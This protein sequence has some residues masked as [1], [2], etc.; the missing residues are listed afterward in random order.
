[1]TRRISE[2][3][4]TKPVKD[5]AVDEDFKAPKSIETVPEEHPASHFNQPKNPQATLL[6]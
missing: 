4:E 3:A 5:Q 2:S 1:L 6:G